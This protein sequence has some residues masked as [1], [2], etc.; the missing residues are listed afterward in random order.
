LNTYFLFRAGSFFTR[1]MSLSGT[2]ML[3]Y[4]VTI[5]L[6]FIVLPC[7]AWPEESFTTA[8]DLIEQARHDCHQFDNGLFQA[9]ERSIR[10]YDLTGDGFPEALVD[11]SQFSCSTALS[12]FGG[13]GGTFLWVIVAGKPYTFLAHQW[14]VVDLDGQNVLLLAVHSSQCSDD[15][16]PCY[17]AFVWQDGF[18]STR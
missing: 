18:R 16:G 7:V 17:R 15:I 12:L 11:A 10:Y 6:F 1:Y 5:I 2:A 8:E 3:G 9:T 4:A 14:W 13:T